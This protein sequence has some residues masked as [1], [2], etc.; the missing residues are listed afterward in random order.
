MKYQAYRICMTL[1]LYGHSVFFGLGTVTGG[2]FDWGGRLPK[3]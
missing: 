1:K 3:R 2:Q